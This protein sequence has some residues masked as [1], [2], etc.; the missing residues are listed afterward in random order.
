[1]SMCYWC[2]IKGQCKQPEWL[3]RAVG[4]DDLYCDAFTPVA[5]PS[6][7]VA[8]VT[9]S[10]VTTNKSV[11]RR[12]W[13]PVTIK[14]FKKDAYFLA[15]NK[16]Q[17]FGGQAI[18]IGRITKDPF[19]EN[20]FIMPDCE[21]TN[22]GFYYLDTEYNDCTHR[23]R[24]LEDAFKSWR[25]KQV[26]LTVVPFETLEIFPGMESKYSTDKEIIRCVKALVR[27]IG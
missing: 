27:V 21:Y 14:R 20:T 3:I 8:Y 26:I 1:M 13:Q 12:H 25:N 23:G 19:K 5:L 10:F 2:K 22:E 9:A 15:W 17:R 16:Q 11:T 24:P 4:N 18:G 7:S 6:I